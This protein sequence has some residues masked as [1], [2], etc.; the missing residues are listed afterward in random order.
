MFVPR[1]SID[2]SDDTLELPVRITA[3]EEGTS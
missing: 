2:G 3:V 1:T